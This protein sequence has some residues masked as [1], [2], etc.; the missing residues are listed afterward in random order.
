MG[1][2]LFEG[3]T[4]AW[5]IEKK[6]KLRQAIR[7]VANWADELVANPSTEAIELGCLSTSMNIFVEEMQKVVGYMSFVTDQLSKEQ[8]REQDRATVSME[9]IDKMI[10]ELITRSNSLISGQEKLQENTRSDFVLFIKTNLNTIINQ[11][12]KFEVVQEA[13]GYENLERIDTFDKLKALLMPELRKLKNE[14]KEFRVL[15]AQLR[16]AGE[17]PH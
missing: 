10:G 2:Y 7:D 1:D 4:I 14:V 11:M 13:V 16:A 6:T 15:L 9:I 12:E 3:R 8:M 17:E 5:C